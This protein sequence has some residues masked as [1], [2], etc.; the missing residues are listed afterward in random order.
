MREILTAILV[1][2]TFSSFGQVWTE[3]Q[4]DSTLTVSI[5]GEYQ[6]VDTMEQRIVTAHFE[7]ALILV[8]KSEKITVT[9]QS[10]KELTEIYTGLQRGVI[11]SQNGKLINSEVTK[12]NGLSFI[13]F[14]YHANMDDEKEVRHCL[15]VF[16]NNHVYTIQ[17]WE[18]EEATNK[19]LAREILFSSLKFPED[20]TSENQRIYST[21]G[22]YVKSFSYFIGLMFDLFIIGLPISIVIWVLKKVKR[23]KTNTP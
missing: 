10:E 1:L 6:V 11:Q 8:S 21:E 23:K 2:F 5:P 13:E 7:N 14:S 22:A 17:F 19:K 3:Y 20:V 4:I 18:P 9:I 16:V 15:G 12:R